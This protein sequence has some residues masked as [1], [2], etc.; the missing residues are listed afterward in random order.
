MGPTSRHILFSVKTFGAGMLA[1]YVAF[2]LDLGQP[3]WALL[4]TYIVSQP[5]A[6]A[7]LAKSAARL[8]GTLLGAVVAVAL[9]SAFAGAREFF[10]VATALWVGACLYGSVLLRE[11]PAA[12]GAMLAGYTA[13]IVGISAVT[14]P[15]S[16]FDVAVA[17]CTEIGLGILCAMLVNHVVF[18]QATGGLLRRTVAESLAAARAWAGDVLRG[19][20][21][22]A[23]GLPDR[24][25]LLGD[26]MTLDTL[27]LQARLDT[28]SVRAVDG[29][30]RLLQ[31]RLFSLLAMLVSIQDRRRLLA[32]DCPER[33]VALTPLMEDLAERIDA[34][35]DGGEAELAARIDAALPDAAALAGDPARRIEYILVA[36]LGDVLRLER[37]MRRL[38]AGIRRG[39]TVSAT[40]PGPAPGR[41]RDH[42][43]ALVGALVVACG[44][45]V[46][47]AFWI[48]AG[49]PQGG[50]AVLQVAIICSFMATQD[51]P[52]AG[53][54][55]FFLAGVVA[56]VVAGIYNFVIFPAISG[57][58]PFVFVLGLFLVPLGLFMSNRRLAPLVTPLILA[59]VVVLGIGNRRDVA[60]DA[61]VNGGVAILAGTGFTVV[62][63]RLLRPAGVEWTV[64]RHLR[65]IR[66]HLGALA[67][68]RG[69]ADRGR[70]ETRM[71]DHLNA[72]I[73][74]LGVAD[75]G[76]RA[77][78]L[79]ALAALRVGL[80]ILLL[81][82]ERIALPPDHGVVVDR[83]LDALAGHFTGRDGGDPIAALDAATDR[84]A[85]SE[86]GLPAEAVAV[87]VALSGIRTSL[88][89]HAGFF[90][91]TTSPTQSA[92]A[93]VAPC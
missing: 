67:T 74:R 37:D 70:F 1:L 55:L 58:V 81:R 75:L 92:Q 13:A 6:G 62:A 5:L 38:V 46:A 35:P 59:T 80:N 40:G 87:F 22:D 2:R 82:R 79:G 11:A 93:E 57:F 61:F 66:R 84:L 23:R 42:A 43:Q 27:R 48:G 25:R 3:G 73:T 77:V 89:E 76:H 88:A 8:G 44:I 45:C 56:L 20:A 49:W 15:L 68:E 19:T 10:V 65:A 28:P 36:R 31:A 71:F 60:F 21:D 7:V 29:A 69:P 51:N 12:Y 90:G 18:P 39:E 34:G 9:V 83:A 32:R 64:R 54:M 86:G 17:R 50:S 4:T 85:G 91:L 24:R 72:L 63:F 47:A 30:L 14:A 33:L 16:V 26:I 41:F 53:A 78:L 52:A